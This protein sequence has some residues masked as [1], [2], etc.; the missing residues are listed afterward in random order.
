MTQLER[1]RLGEVTEEMRLVAAEEELDAGSLRE[2]V[3]AGRVVIPR[4]K[5]RQN[6]KRVCG[7]GGGLRIKVNANVGTSARSNDVGM[8]VEKIRAA[9]DAGADAIM[10]LSTGGSPED[11]DLMRRTTLEESPVCVGTVPIYQAAIEAIQKRGAI[12]EMTADDIFST[13]EK[14][15]R[16]GVDFV[17]VHCG[18]TLESLN[19]M[20]TEGR[21][22]HIVSRGGAF[23]AAWMLHNRVENP[24]YAQFDRL[25]EIAREYDVTLSLGDGFRP[26]CLADATDRAQV[27]ETIILGELVDRARKAGVQ[28]MVEGP[29]HVP[30][31][32]IQANIALQKRLC[33]DA[34][35]YVLGPLVTDVAAGHDHVAAAIGA[36]VAGMYGADFICYV[37]P[38]EH[39]GL[40]SVDDVREGVIAARIA[41]HAADLARGLKSAWQ[42]DRR[43]TVARRTFD[44]QQQIETAIYPRK[45]QEYWLRRSKDVI[46]DDHPREC[47]MCGPYC[48]MR[49]V[50][51]FLSVPAEES[52]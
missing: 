37:T 27:Q 50:D 32:Q 4:N 19:R 16:D 13:I 10:D 21:L 36:A 5:V 28:A 24:L 44:W 7:I 20:R 1:A 26:G 49:I 2:A 42:R 46:D 47:S 29:G 14:H 38:S 6:L 25:L 48:A 23:L 52:A 12:V 22:A 18:V 35:F 3:A 40:P 9:V 31:H 45:A 39:L 17:T 33:H 15:A 51:E 43:M 8:E 30:L 41:G 11:I 34:P